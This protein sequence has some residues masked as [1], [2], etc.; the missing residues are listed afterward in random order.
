MIERHIPAIQLQL[1][2]GA[3]AYRFDGEDCLYRDFDGRRVVA[4]IEG[5][6][7]FQVTGRADCFVDGALVSCGS[8]QFNRW[9]RVVAQDDGIVE[10]AV[11][12]ETWSISD[13]EPILR[14]RVDEVGPKFQN[15]SAIRTLESNFENG[16]AHIGLVASFLNRLEFQLELPGP[17]AIARIYDRFH[18]RQRS[19]VL[20]NGEERSIW[21]SPSENRANR[22]HWDV[23]VVSPPSPGL[24]SLAIDPSAG[25]PLWSLSELLILPVE[26]LS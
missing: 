20:V 11:E 3:I 24:C 23:V 22:W 17:I 7:S 6:G 25:Y 12:S 26:K 14:F 16:E 9:L 19:R 18:G 10:T 13:R 8:G 21:F 4:D 1:Q 5:S 2:S 15:R